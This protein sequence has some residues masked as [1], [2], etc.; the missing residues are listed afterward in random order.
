[1]RGIET[2]LE[3]DRSAPW[4]A[5]L[6]YTWSRAEDFVANQWT[7]RSW[8]QPHAVQMRALWQGGPWHVSG[9]LS[10]HSGWP[11]T[12]LL[13][14]NTE[15]RDPTTVGVAFGPRNSERLDN[16][17][18]LDLRVT[19]QHP[20]WGGV[21]QASFEL[22]NATNAKSK[23]CE[24]YSVVSEPGGVSSLIETPAYWL[25]IM[26]IIGVRWRN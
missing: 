12:P 21:L 22:L 6:S 5:S 3:S 4:S 1:M 9:V 7:P 17:V 13:V 25:T 10:W 16:Y 19:W 23:C 8:D 24:Q 11:F 26:P 2:T 18:S 14:S 20:L 15:W